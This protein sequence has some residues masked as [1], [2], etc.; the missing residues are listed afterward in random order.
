MI[1]LKRGVGMSRLSVFGFTV[2][3]PDMIEA[4]R[5]VVGRFVKPAHATAEHPL[6]PPPVSETPM[7]Q[8][9]H[10]LPIR[11]DFPATISSFAQMASAQKLF[12]ILKAEGLENAEKPLRINLAYPH[13]DPD[14]FPD[15]FNEAEGYVDHFL[16]NFQPAIQG[17][18]WR[19]AHEIV[20]MVRLGRSEDQTSV[21]ALTARQ[22]YRLRDPETTPETPFRFKDP[23]TGVPELFIIVD[24]CIEQGTTMANLMSH[25]EKEGGRVIAVAAAQGGKNLLQDKVTA[26]LVNG[27]KRP[28]DATGSRFFDPE[29]NTGRLPHL[30]H[31]FAQAAAREGLKISPQ[32]CMDIFEGRLNLF[33]NT[34]F[35][36]TEGECERLAES[37]DR[38]GHYGNRISFRSLITKLDEKLATYAQ[39]NDAAPPAKQQ[40]TLRLPAGM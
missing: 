20:E 2:E 30:A 21:H 27:E 34:V 4:G 25:I 39:K 18:E 5:Q 14:L 9:P 3:W 29:K 33:G 37:L 8:N 15:H 22:E 23:E 38:S 1:Y 32:K 13:K 40:A 36:L 6:G 16:R 24:D 12:N 10:R 7:S 17:V 19:R 31:S 11:P 28:F 26:A 35:A